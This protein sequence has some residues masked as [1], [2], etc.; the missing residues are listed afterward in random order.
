MH[1]PVLWSEVWVKDNSIDPDVC[2][3]WSFVIRA[4]NPDGTMCGINYGFGPEL[5]DSIRY[6]D[7]L[8]NDVG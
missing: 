5:V 1:A 2:R 4:G 8:E 6:V 7:D 3:C